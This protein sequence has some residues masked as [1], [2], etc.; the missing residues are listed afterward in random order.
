MSGDEVFVLVISAIMG[1]VGWRS[2]LMLKPFPR[3]ATRVLGYVTPLLCAVILFG[4]L[5][6][7]ASDDVRHDSTYL[8]FYMVFGFGW[9]GLMNRMLPYLGLLSRDDVLERGNLAAALAVSGAL[10]GLTLAFAGGNIGNGRGWWVVLFCAVLATGTLFV[11]WIIANSF[12]RVEEAI[13]IDRDVAAGWRTLGFFIG[14]GLI[15]GRAVAGDW[16]STG[17]TL[18]YFVRASWMALVLTI[19]SIVV[20][21][22]CLPTPEMPVRNS[23]L[24]GFLPGLGYLA[25]GMVTV[26]LEGA[27]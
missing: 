7:W 3:T 15:L 11:L 19:G 20:D 21:R 1:V 27:W 22:Y 5:R 8:L 26:K 12:S 14:N 17:E 4:V 18:V 13:T 2:L 16:H 24:F 9:L 25:A 23:V 10:T 6:R